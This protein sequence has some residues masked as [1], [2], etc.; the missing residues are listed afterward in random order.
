MGS[1]NVVL[2]RTLSHGRQGTLEA[3][4]I[5]VLTED[6][7]GVPASRGAELAAKAWAGVNPAVEVT[8]RALGGG[9]ARTAD[10]WAGERGS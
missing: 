3:M 9:G 7:P 6:W 8:A 10:A 4:R 5:L 1:E 2:M